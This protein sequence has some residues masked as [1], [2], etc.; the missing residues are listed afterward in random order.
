[1]PLHLSLERK[2]S[3]SIPESWMLSLYSL[4]RDLR[5]DSPK[6]SS[7]AFLPLHSLSICGTYPYS[8]FPVSHTDL[9]PTTGS[10]LTQWLWYTSWNINVLFDTLQPHMQSQLIRFYNTRPYITT[11]SKGPH[12]NW[13]H[14]RDRGTSSRA[15]I[16]NPLFRIQGPLLR[17][18]ISE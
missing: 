5:D 15:Q 16:A 4:S 8:P 13:S 9:L 18:H 12:Q 11:V 3:F 17:P 1:M 7:C 10:F 14:F 6:F 2:T